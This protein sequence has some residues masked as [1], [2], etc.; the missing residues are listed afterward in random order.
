MKCEIKKKTKKK[1][2]NTK[3]VP[4]NLHQSFAVEENWQP[5]SH[6]SHKQSKLVSQVLQEILMP[7]TGKKERKH[8]MDSS[9]AL[10]TDHL[11]TL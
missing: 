1:P 10:L 8:I 11:K 3:K 4:F 9:I 2:N 7:L 6:S 5:N